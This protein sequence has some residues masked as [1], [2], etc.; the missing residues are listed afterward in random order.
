MN[1][2]KIS[3]NIINK[4]KRN[5]KR[6]CNSVNEISY[7]QIKEMIK[8]N[9][10]ILLDVRSVQEYNE[11]HLNSAINIPLSELK[12]KAPIILNC[13]DIIIAYCQVGVRSKKAAVI[14]NKLG[15][16]NVYTLAGG[17]DNICNY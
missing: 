2:D 7:A 17:L 5:L 6:E 11:G 12:I 14:L 9:T 8:H 3:E 15:Y 1:F 4:L 10:V 13:N 16:R